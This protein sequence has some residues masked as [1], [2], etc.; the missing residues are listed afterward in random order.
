MKLFRRSRRQKVLLFSPVIMWGHVFQVPAPQLLEVNHRWSS[1]SS[2]YVLLFNITKNWYERLKLNEK[3]TSSL[4]LNGTRFAFKW[5]LLSRPIVSFKKSTIVER[6]PSKKLQLDVKSG[7]F[8]LCGGSWWR[9]G[10]DGN[11]HTLPLGRHSWE[12][13]SCGLIQ[14]TKKRLLLHRPTF[15][16]NIYSSLFFNNRT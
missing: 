12:V 1:S 11:C 9:S 16:F 13:V 2:F 3:T 14:L 10:N 6:G 5:Y 7:F 15:L 8:R 4:D